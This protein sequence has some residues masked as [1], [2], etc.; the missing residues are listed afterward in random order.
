MPTTALSATASH[1]PP[2]PTAARHWPPLVWV[3][4]TGTFAVR[5]AGF[6][7]PLLSYRLADLHLGV[8]RT[9][10]V[11]SAFGVGW[12]AGQLLCGWL[13]DRIGQRLTLA[14][15][16]LLAA[17][18][19]PLLAQVRS[20]SA[21]TAAAAVSGLV[22]YAP[23]PIVTAAIADTVTSGAERARINGWRHF[24]TNL[25]AA[26]TGAAGGALAGPLGISPLVWCNAIV[27]GGF[28]LVVLAVMPPG[29]AVRAA[30]S[31]GG[32]RQALS[33]TRLWL[34]WLASLA[35]LIPVAGLF[36]I[37]PLMMT[38]DGLPVSAYG[39]TQL[40]SAAAVLVLSPLLNPWLARRAARPTAMVGHLALGS[41][42]LGAGIGSAGLAST[43]AGYVVAAVIAVPGEICAFVAATDIL[44]R[45]APAPARGLYAGIWGTTLAA[46]VMSAPL[47]AGWS[48]TTGGDQLV[49]LTTLASGLLG[50]ALCAPL[51][52]LLHRPARHDTSLH[53]PAVTQ[54]P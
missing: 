43:P 41:V 46:A 4:L 52:A 48:I 39:W 18:V 6:C 8:H 3:L 50:A 17:A 40:A 7:Y 34:L 33:D 15:A 12:L 54:H 31:R 37:L 9:S 38:H 23:W 1:P 24:A 21:V 51:A 29:G 47:L 13:A 36:S 5:A 10:A 35:A 32:H 44:H 16:M 22:Y 53:A 19:F 30:H 25:G 27:C 14:G 28:A 45:I 42:V 26:V 11:L 2:L 20:P 49:G